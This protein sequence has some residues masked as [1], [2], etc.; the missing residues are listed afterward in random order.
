MYGNVH[1]TTTVTSLQSTLFRHEA[2]DIIRNAVKASE[3]DAV[4]FVGSGCT[5]AIHKL[6]NALDL[7]VPPVVFVSP[8]EHHSNILPWKELGS[9]VIRIPQNSAGLVDV[10]LLETELQKW[11]SSDRQLIGCFSA[12]S[13]ITGILSDTEGITLLLHRYNALAVWDYATAG[14]YVDI[15][16]NP[17]INGSD[18]CAA[19]K[20]AIFISP[21]KF[22]GGVDTPGVL[23]AKK[24]LFRNSTPT[25]GGGG[26]VFFVSRE[27]HRYLKQ[28]EMREE[29]GTPSIVGAIRAGL[30]FQLKEAVG[31]DVIMKREEEL[32]HKA[33]KRWSS[34]PNLIL[35]GSQSVPR[36]LIF[37]FLVQ[38]PQTKQFLHYSFLCALLNDL[39]GIQTRGGCAC[40]GPYAQD[41]LGIDEK[42][43]QEYEKLLL[44]DS[45]LDRVHLRRYHEYSDREV[46]R[47][48]FVRLNLPYFMKDDCISFVLDAV[49]MVSEHG[50]KLLPQYM[51]NPETGEWKQR[52]HQVFQDRRWLG[53]ISYASGEMQVPPPPTVKTKGPFPTS[54]QECLDYA[55]EIFVT[56]QKKSR[57]LSLPDQT[58]LFQEE[59]ERLRWFMLPSEAL[60]ILQANPGE[61]QALQT[62]PFDPPSYPLNL[63][64]RKVTVIE[65]LLNECARVCSHIGTMTQRQA[66]NILALDGDCRTI[67]D[68]HSD[69]SEAK[70]SEDHGFTETNKASCKI[71]NHIE[72]NRSFPNLEGILRSERNPA[73]VQLPSSGKKSTSNSAFGEGNS[74]MGECKEFDDE[75]E[76]KKSR[77]RVKDSSIYLERGDAGVVA[78]NIDENN[79]W[80][81]SDSITGC[82]RL[83]NHENNCIVNVIDE[84]PRLQDERTSDFQENV[85]PSSNHNLVNDKVTSSS[86]HDVA[87]DSGDIASSEQPKLKINVSEKETFDKDEKGRFDKDVNREGFQGDS[88]PGN[89]GPCDNDRA[90]LNIKFHVPPKK[91]FKPAVQALEEYNMITDGDRLLVCLSGGKDSLSLLHTIRQYQFYAKKKGIN[92]EFGAVTVDPQTPSFDP[93]PLKGYLAKLGVPYFYEE[94]CIIEQASNVEGGCDSICSFCSRMKRGRIYA[95]ARREGYNV[96]AM[97]QHLDDLAESFL[98]SVFHNGLL[99]TMKANY[100]VKE[101]DL[102]VI[103]PFVYVRE[104]D[105]R[106]FAQKAKLPV[107]PEN[108]PACF[109]APK[110]RHRT[111][112]LLA[113]QEIL[114]PRLYQSLQSAMKPLMAK[115]R[116]GM[117]SIHR[118]KQAEEDCDEVEL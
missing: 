70:L 2:R 51:F 117:E 58:L 61:N 67:I 57:S 28:I 92:F 56:A 114:F 101:G 75:T 103:R 41:V 77:T 4:I 63:H 19:Q 93:S 46:L 42:L 112:Q 39:F 10:G 44:E 89:F 80:S 43:A 104:K 29:G 6:V 69:N 14:P 21:H 68:S 55:E 12:A 96:L 38:H 22:V 76:D 82:D 35:L 72:D 64:F 62:M 48:G 98:M 31:A 50:W 27:R 87:N 74:E 95:A 66:S 78:P 108:C 116:T 23:V 34:C 91:L 115:N 15:N 53:S 25:E 106:E 85:T 3:H 81:E 94:Q 110:E 105:L 59:A 102:R 26:S 11:Q 33:M 100:L 20:D 40:A 90:A 8:F 97:G 47:P 24:Y 79:T 73:L 60:S 107:I 52:H 65:G 32:C 49:A 86:D 54:Y 30:A 16:M 9:T 83:V 109:E 17:V 7:Q 45:R 36:L 18:Q 118:K 113:A 13:N 88:E 71:S 1:T 84:G 37:S 111:K 5:G 99:R